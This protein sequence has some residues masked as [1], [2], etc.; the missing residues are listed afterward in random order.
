MDLTGKTAAGKPG[1]SHPQDPV[2]E[3]RDSYHSEAIPLSG[4]SQPEHPG[5]NNPPAEVWGA[6]S[7]S[8]PKHAAELIGKFKKEQIELVRTIGFGGLL[9]LQQINGIDRRFTTWLLSRVNCDSRTLRVG[10][11]LDVELSPRNVHRVLGIPFEG[12]DVCP[13]P[14]NSKEERDTFVQHYI[15]APGFESSAL[16]GA[17]EVIK[18]TF[19]DGMN[20]WARDHFRTAFLELIR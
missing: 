10:N 3:G 18:R 11:N 19:P 2:T 7:R 15:G 6:T 16:K 17:E 13:M 8:S 1:T 4:F 20:S 9:E 12:M 14:D 5:H